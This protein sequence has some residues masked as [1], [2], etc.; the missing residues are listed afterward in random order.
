M[1]QPLQSATELLKANIQASAAT[2]QS[3]VS[4]AAPLEKAGH[5]LTHC[6]VS[7]HKLI[8]CGNGGSASD[9]SHIATEFVA[10]F[11]T[12]RRPYPALSLTDSGSTMTAIS[13]DYA[14]EQVFARQVRAFAKPGD[15]LLAITTS[16]KS[17]N[18]LLA[19]EAAKELGV[20]SIAFLGKGGGF[21]KGVATIDLIVPSEVTARVQE[22]HLLL[23]HCLCELVDAE[24]IRQGA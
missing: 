20:T 7:G 6:L 14:F 23:Y 11:H 19:L 18:I 4:L 3:L 9:A 24:L 5:A 12:D 8:T 22:S 13:N 2:F 15:V 21:T 1:P 17:K 16:G 10:R